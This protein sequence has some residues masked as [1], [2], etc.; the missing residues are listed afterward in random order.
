MRRLL[1]R[2]RLPQIK[3]KT[4]ILVIYFVAAFALGGTAGVFGFKYLSV[5]KVKYSYINSSLGCSPNTNFDKS[6]PIVL[7]D[8]LMSFINSEQK[9]GNI[10]E[11]SVYFRD[12]SDGPTLGINEDD[13]FISASL[14]K[15]PIALTYYKLSEEEIPDI[16][17]QK[18][19]FQITRGKDELVQFFKPSKS[20]D[21]NSTYTVSD[22]IF[23]S[24]AYSDNL[25]NDVLR[26]Y[27]GTVGSGQDFLLRTFKE[28]G[29][30][31]PASITTSDISTRAYASIFRQLY[32]ASYLS[33]EDS[34]KILSILAQ[35]EF[36]L[37][38]VGGVPKEVKVA[39]KFGERD[40][41]KEKQLHDCGIVYYPGNPYLICVM[42]RGT[43][44]GR[45][46]DVIKEISSIVYK[47]MDSRAK[48]K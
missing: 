22:L 41:N 32:N 47:E 23:Y 44:Y 38:I 14:L 3:N 40:L 45:L 43:D 7:K 20:V 10:N 15:L 37:G 5:C 27:L 35:S 39:N 36:D 11:A 13:L 8:K 16:L 9:S 25:S 4:I 17:S 42:T 19:G 21:P 34:E 26:T 2:I 24:L 31:E 30:V 46:A 1:D 18:L 33:N 48:A 6:N 28:L 29:L 12:L